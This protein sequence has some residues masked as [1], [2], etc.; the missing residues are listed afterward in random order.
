M[1][2]PLLF[3]ALLL[4]TLV[5]LIGPVDAATSPPE[6]PGEFMGMVVRDPHYEWR[7]NPDYPGVNQAFFDAMGE[8][9]RL[10]GVKWIRI[11]FRAED[12]GSDFAGR[13]RLEQYDYLINTVAPRNGFKVLALLATPLAK[14]PEGEA[15]PGQVTGGYI[16]PKL[17]E[18]PAPPSCRPPY[19]C[20]TNQYMRIWLDNA[21][22][23]VKRFPYDRQ[24]GTGIA[25]YEVLNEQN[26][27]LNG[28]G[29]GM[30]PNQVAALLTKFYRVFKIE[31][32]PDGSFGT[33]RNDV[34]VILGGLHPG[35]CDDCARPDGGV[36]MN[37]REYLDAVY[38]SSAF[39]NFASANGRLPLDGV[40]YHPYPDQMQSGLVPEHSGFPDLYRV[41]G[42]MRAVRDVMLR[43]GDVANKFWITEI[44]ERGAPQDIDN[45]RRQAAFLRTMYWMLWQQRDYIKNVFWF[46]YEDFA[47]PANPGA[48]GPE[49]W[50]VVRL[51][52]PQPSDRCDGCEYNPNGVVQ[53]YKQ[54]FIAYAR[55]S[56]FGAGLETHRVF[57][58][59]VVNQ[60]GE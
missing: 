44:G 28:G 26:R 45:Q 16:D 60:G 18:A 19:L 38:R 21:F 55:M 50:G 53:V 20:G 14:W 35:R 5:G 32:G 40:G 34:D 37:D 51:L 58:P 11:E 10:A 47:V 56:R 8:N 39:R 15:P 54:S 22:E 49:N 23:I 36:G 24:R 2:R 31:G 27:Y 30:D 9:L 52:P 57:V 41:P 33:W 48:I 7:T 29:R 42:R 25:A 3:A 13:V 43:N 46:K 17:I 4:A 59:L 1:M 6:L 12:P